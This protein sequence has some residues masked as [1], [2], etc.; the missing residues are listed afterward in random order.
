[1]PPGWQ[2]HPPVPQPVG[3]APTQVARQYLAWAWVASA[4][5]QTSINRHAHTQSG[6]SRYSRPVQ[7]TNCPSRP[8]PPVRQSTLRSGPQ[9]CPVQQP[10][11]QAKVPIESGTAKRCRRKSQKT[12]IAEGAKTEQNLGVWARPRIGSAFS[13]TPAKKK[14]G[15]RQL[16]CEAKS[17][18]FCQAWA[19]DGC[20]GSQ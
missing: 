10:D 20:L 4:G 18:S 1:M 12:E 16:A 15:V 9:T 19:I 13:K 2:Q 14:T 17:T 8:V 11:R 5:P 3:A 6:P 7:V